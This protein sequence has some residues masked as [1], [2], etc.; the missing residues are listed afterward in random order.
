L[1]RALLRAQ[2][3]DQPKRR[4][5]HDSDLFHFLSLH[6]AP[7]NET[8]KRTRD[9]AAML[10]VNFSKSNRSFVRRSTCRGEEIK[11]AQDVTMTYNTPVSH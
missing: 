1:R 4:D 3:A 2:G 7:I 11:Q 10:P 6:G 5:G 8:A 9:P